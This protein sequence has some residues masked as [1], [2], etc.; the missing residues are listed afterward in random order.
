MRLDVTNPMWRNTWAFCMG[1]SDAYAGIDHRCVTQ[2]IK[3]WLRVIDAHEALH[4]YWEG[5]LEGE[6]ERNLKF[7]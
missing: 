3:M 7:W 2:Q 4:Y 1:F 5:R 6:R